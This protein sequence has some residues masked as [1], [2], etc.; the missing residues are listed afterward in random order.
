[1]SGQRIENMSV[2]GGFL[3][4]LRIPFGPGLIC[5]IGARGTGKTTAVEFIGYALDSL[6]SREHAAEERKRIETL[7]KRNLGGPVDQRRH[8]GQRRVCVQGDAIRRG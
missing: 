1:M 5:L 2:I 7:V 3:D 4:G 6:P 8:S